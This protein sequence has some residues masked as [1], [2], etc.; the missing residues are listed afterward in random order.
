MSVT[1]EDTT[2]LSSASIEDVT[3]TPQTLSEDNTEAGIL[4]AT[5]L[6][7]ILN[8]ELTEDTTS[9]DINANDDV[10][11]DD[12]VSLGGSVYKPGGR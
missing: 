2:T 6:A 4:E 1:S 12:D 9:G 8:T 10:Y 3:D 5:T 11:N 7:T